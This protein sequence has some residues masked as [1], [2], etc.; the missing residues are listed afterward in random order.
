M[1]ASSR[2]SQPGPQKAQT[3]PAMK[4]GSSV[5]GSRVESLPSSISVSSKIDKFST[6]PAPTFLSEFK[7]RHY[8][9]ED[10]T[11]SRAPSGA[12]SVELSIRK[13]L[14]Q[15]RLENVNLREAV[16]N[17]EMAQFKMNFFADEVGRLTDLAQAEEAEMD[18]L[19]QTKAETAA[20]KQAKIEENK[21][22]AEEL[23]N[24][25]SAKNDMQIKVADAKRELERLKA[26]QRDRE[27]KRRIADTQKRK[28][29][30][31]K[32]KGFFSW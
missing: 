7:E 22:L 3:S 19:R 17:Y 30:E 18:F 23:L 1:K 13:Q 5:T 2:A 31:A 10:L 14:E 26:I 28:E 9:P 21:Y 15:A 8:D 25:R 29:E 32:N 24:A 11:N 16:L 4:V 20:S 12:T 27:T 6:A